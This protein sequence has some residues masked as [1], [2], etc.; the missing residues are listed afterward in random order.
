MNEYGISITFKCNWHCDYCIINTHAQPEVEFSKL[1]EKIESIEPCSK[2]SV[3]GGEPGLASKE[4]VEYVINEL[5][6]K[7]CIIEINTNGEFLRKYYYLNDKIDHYFYHISEDLLSLNIVPNIDHTKIDFM[8]TVTDDMM[9][10]IDDFLLMYNKI[11]HKKIFMYA[12]FNLL[13]NSKDWQPK[14]LSKKNALKLIS[15]YKNIM[16][17]ECLE[18][19]FENCLAINKKANKRFL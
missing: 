12:A 8:I 11:I 1:K 15:K 7:N 9:S 14:T 4:V 10:R 6:K 16:D 17:K 2:V 13:G 18:Y 3:T 19:I 5:F